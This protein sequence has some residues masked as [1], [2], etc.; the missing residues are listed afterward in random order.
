MNNIYEQI[1]NLS[2]EKRAVF[3]KMLLE[4][5]VDLSQM[6]I[7]PRTDKS[8]GAPLSFSQQRL[9]FLDQL[10]PGSPLYNICSPVRIK[11]KL[12][13]D[14][15]Q[16]TLNTIV[17][18][19][20]V[21]RSVIVSDNEAPLQQVLSTNSLKITKINESD[22]NEIEALIKEEATTPFDLQ[23]GPL[24][25]FS[26]ITVSETENIIILTLHH[27]VSDNWSTGVLI[28]EF[29]LL[30]QGYSSGSIPQLPKL[31]IQY[32]DF[33]TWQRKWLSGK[34]L[35][36]QFGFWHETLN[37]VPSV[38][39]MPY[40][41]VRPAMQTYNGDYKM[42]SIT[43]SK[44]NSLKE[45]ADAHEATLF[46]VLMALFQTLLFKYTNQQ[47]F[48]VGTPIANR[49]RSE[50]EALI[51]FFINTLVVRAD[52]SD[53]P[54]FI[55]VLKKVKERTIAA[56]DHQDIPF[57]TLVEKLDPQRDMSHT[58]LFQAMLVLNNAPVGKL[59]LPGLEMEL[60]EFE[61][62]T[63]KFDLI[64]NF[65]EDN[66]LLETR[67]EY[68]T[69][70]YA[71]VSIEQMITVFNVLMDQVLDHPTVSI[72][73]L[74][75]L[76]ST[77][78]QALLDSIERDIEVVHSKKLLCEMIDSNS[79]RADQK[80]AVFAGGR[81]LSYAELKSESD[82]V[83]SYL[84][85]KGIKPGDFVAVL[86]HRSPETIYAMLGVLKAGAVYLPMDPAYP[87][88]RLNFMLRDSGAKIVIT[89]A[90]DNLIAGLQAPDI[91]YI[92]QINRQSQT[93]PKIDPKSPAYI[94]Y[95]SGTTGNPKGVLVSHQAIADHCLDMAQKFELTPADNVLQFAALNFDASLE[96]IFPT[97][98]SG[99]GL[100]L[101]DDDVWSIDEFVEQVEKHR[102]TVINPPTA[103]WNQLTVNLA[104]T[105]KKLPT[106]VRLV[107]AGGDVMRSAM[108]KKWQ[109]AEICGG[110][111]LNAYGP[112][113]AIITSSIYDV[114][115]SDD[116][117]FRRS[118]MPIG[119]ACANRKF[120]ILDK[121]QQLLPYG[122][123]GELCIGGSSL[124]IGYHNN[125]DKSNDAFI[126]NVFHPGERIY[127]TGDKAR[128]LPDGI[129]QFLGRIDDQLKIRGFRIEPEEIEKN[130]L[131]NTDVYQALVISRPGPDGEKQLIAYYISK[132]G[133]SPSPIE[134]RQFLKARLPEYMLP[135]AFMSLDEFPV[136]PAGK[137]DHS[138]LPLPA[139]LR[140]QLSTKFVAPRSETETILA[141][142]VC[143]VLNIEKV[144]VFDNFFDLG[145]HSMLGTQVVS[146][147]RE[148]LDIEL[149][150]RALFENPTVEGIA[151]TIAEIQASDVNEEDLNELLDELEGLNEEDIN[152]LLNSDNI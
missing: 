107:I 115:V 19:H 62:K 91:I 101:R 27:I 35:E 34:T 56:F 15:V 83:A 6:P 59:L 125:P 71:A 119:K 149:P 89:D 75:M 70:V 127:R 38:L 40:D 128:L 138:A 92:G 69:D 95:T 64:F 133:N 44:L 151:L 4:E 110:R 39:D 54:D 143:Q 5:G 23:K 29:M 135:A 130:I 66:G 124:A 13:F 12:N 42:F 8:V 46:M 137:I 82:S 105:G 99:A 139:D 28:R 136:T 120:Y 134:L 48:C 90:A 122:L 21:L 140:D 96:Q 73:E 26:C 86:A 9:W 31:S 145:G 20:H 85:S 121:N 16:Q 49:N 93:L 81:N 50:I 2:P 104:E 111:L 17:E 147:I 132:P 14:A 1:A 112:T 60:I 25:R 63:S 103:Y 79:S 87:V 116:T 109:N 55:S 3:E 47:D 98:L 129:V 142:I 94:I 30:Y 118:S 10:E 77:E 100:Y 80:M 61:N 45:I 76:D 24:I 102:L 141:D 68:N 11:G 97:L 106:F 126:N 131:D 74:H 41:F 117:I 53:N 78:R 144:G 51:G 148:Q 37:G 67:I 72:N 123:P 32:A 114:P 43:A 22:P 146:R 108:V 57:E 33:A 88:D 52:F 113:E 18:R 36:K 58:P 84:L 150:L 152:N 7:L 65:T